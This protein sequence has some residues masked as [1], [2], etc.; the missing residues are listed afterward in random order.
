MRH[1][2]LPFIFNFFPFVNGPILAFRDAV[3][4]EPPLTLLFVKLLKFLFYPI[5]EGNGQFLKLMY[6]LQL[7]NILSQY[8]IL[9]QSFP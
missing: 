2:Y 3:S 9:Y 1:D 4:L 5:P 8:A 7:P 6:Y